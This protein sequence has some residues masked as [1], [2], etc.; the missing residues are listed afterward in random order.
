VHIEA[1]RRCAKRIVLNEYTIDD[2]SDSICTI[3]VDDSSHALVEMGV[4]VVFTRLPGSFK[5]EL[6]DIVDRRV[7]WV[8]VRSRTS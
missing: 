7:G 5:D 6:A 4:L 8:P 1:G 2:S 3:S